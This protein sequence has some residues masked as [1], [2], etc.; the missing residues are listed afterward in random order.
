MYVILVSVFCRVYYW[1]ILVERKDEA[2]AM[3]T[4]QTDFVY[5]SGLVSSGSFLVFAF[6]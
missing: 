1:C 6:L 2:K 4:L 5:F 3:V